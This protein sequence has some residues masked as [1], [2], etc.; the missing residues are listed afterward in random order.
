ML[1]QLLRAGILLKAYLHVRARYKR[2]LI[3]V[4]GFILILYLH[5][6][7]LAWADT[8]SKINPQSVQNLSTWISSSFLIKN[9]LLT[10]LL[11]TFFGNYLLDQMRFNKNS[12][13]HKSGDSPKNDNLA[14]A[15]KDSDTKID[16]ANDD[17]GFD[18]LRHK[19]KLSF[20]EDLDIT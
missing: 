10:L 11:A 15:G 18:F 8:N 16:A 3:L 19:K 4:L 14:S 20:G 6:E 17:D 2:Y 13:M 12:V 9:A 1:M 5:S 7:L